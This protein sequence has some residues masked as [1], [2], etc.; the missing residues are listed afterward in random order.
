MNRCRKMLF[1]VIA[2]FLSAV[3]FADENNSADN[4]GSR[5]IYGIWTEE[6]SY[7]EYLKGDELLAPH[8]AILDGR[9]YLALPNCIYISK[10]S[11]TIRAP[12]ALLRIYKIQGHEIY[13]GIKNGKGNAVLYAEQTSPAAMTLTVKKADKDFEENQYFFTRGMKENLHLCDSAETD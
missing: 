11:Q 13:V 1:A 3:L 9:K 8:V 2:A 10:D 5:F 4:D 6:T 12:G 7:A